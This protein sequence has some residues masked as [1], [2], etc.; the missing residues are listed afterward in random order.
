[1]VFQ[2]LVRISA[3]EPPDVRDKLALRVGVEGGGCHGYQYTMALTEEKGVD[4]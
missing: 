1:M 2:Q 4:D 3:R